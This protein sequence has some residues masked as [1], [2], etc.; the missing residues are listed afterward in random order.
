[1]QRDSHPAEAGRPLVAC[2]DCGL[3]HALPD[4]P[5]GEK[6]VCSRCGSS[7]RANLGHGLHRSAAFSV[8]A[9]ILLAVATMFPLLV[10]ELEGREQPGSILSAAGALWNVGYPVLA[11]LVFLTVLAAPLL[12]ILTTLYVVLPLLA[13]RPA[14]G[15]ARVFRMLDHL[16]PWAMVE[17]FLLGLIV[18]Y[19]KLSDIA[20]VEIGPS[21][22]ALVGLMVA[23]TWAEA[24]L[25]PYHVWD[26]LSPQLRTG[27]AGAVDIPPERLVRCHACG[28]LAEGEH[29]PCPRCGAP[30]HR[31]KPH[32]FH[33]TAAL[34]AAAAILY[35]PANLLPIMTVVYFGSGEADTILSGVETLIESGML[36]IALLVFFASIAVPVLKLAGL[37]Y[38]LLSVSRRSA[39]R[40]KDRTRLYRL[41]DGVGRWSMVDIF[42]ISLLTSLVQLGAIATVQAEPGAVAFAMVV[43]ITMRASHAFDPRLMWDAAD[44]RQENSSLG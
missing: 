20:T 36:P 5:A 35:I 24:A 27:T 12:K 8:A 14:P 21:L 25:D 40:L 31:R 41:I 28:Q 18:A 38:L 9:L 19:V 26:R 13:G 44:T 29:R 11:A 37:S 2:P 7:L 10:F 33:R 34:A 32:S 1:M 15:T 4:M 23:L 16:K 17:V 30:L 42:M 39:A 22:F 43:I 6:A 3:L